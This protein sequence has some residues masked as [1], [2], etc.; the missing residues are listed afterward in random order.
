MGDERRTYFC[1]L[2]PGN[3]TDDNE[4]GKPDDNEYES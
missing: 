4:R 2:G 3:Y 1:D